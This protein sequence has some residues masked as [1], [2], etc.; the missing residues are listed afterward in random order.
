MKNGDSVISSELRSRI[1]NV[2]ETGSGTFEGTVSFDPGFRGF[3]GHFPGR[4]IVPGVCL[5]E[6]VRVFA[7]VVLKRKL[8][9]V[10]IPQCRF[11]R[12]VEAGDEVKCRLRRTKCEGAASEWSADISVPDGGTACQMRM[13]L[14]EP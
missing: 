4:P 13:R 12:P 8:R 11:R 5:I 2:A 7:E 9:C 1:R 6:L 14:E 10:G 3:E